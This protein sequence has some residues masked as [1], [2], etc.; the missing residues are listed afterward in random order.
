MEERVLLKAKKRSIFGKRLGKLRGNNEIPAILYGHN[1]K[2]INISVPENFF[3]KVYKKVGE[4]S[5]IDLAV[6]NDKPIKV[7]I[8]DYQRDHCKGNIIHIDFYKVKMDEKMRVKIPINFIG[9]SLAVK[10]LGGVLVN[11]ITEI[12]VMCLPQDL[13]QK[14]DVDIS[15]LKTFN[16]SIYVKDLVIP[17]TMKILLHTEDIVSKVVPPRSEKELEALETKSAEDVSTVKVV[18]QEEKEKED[19]A[20]EEKTSEEQKEKK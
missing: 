5:L 6:D 17:A 7:I 12:E 19:I 10:D 1:F 2:N 15:K 4:S 9:E 18:G 20:Q 16:D 11:N 14:I 13:I 8:Q 3:T